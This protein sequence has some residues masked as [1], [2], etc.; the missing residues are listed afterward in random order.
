MFDAFEVMVISTYFFPGRT[1]EAQQLNDILLTYLYDFTAKT[2]MPFVI[3]G[4]FY[5]RIQTL[6]AWQA[7]SNLQCVEGFDFALKKL[8]KDLPPTCRN[9]T[10]FD[11]FIFHPL[12]AALVTDMWV[13][14]SHL[15]SDH[16]P[17]YARISCDKMHTLPPT[18]F[19]PEDWSCFPIQAD[20]FAQ[21]YHDTAQE[22][23]LT[24]HIESDSVPV[25]HKVR[26]W[27]QTVEKALDRTLR[28]MHTADPIY[29]CV[30]SRFAITSHSL[31]ANSL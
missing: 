19:V 21:K 23:F 14:P 25:E 4:D 5:Q 18:L 26:L 2:S 16:S 30:H 3:A 20:L 22:V 13:G 6:T 10:R 12:I 24:T 27:S 15:F 8:G 28:L 9:S 17:I 11:S 31:T 7:F 29:S 1:T